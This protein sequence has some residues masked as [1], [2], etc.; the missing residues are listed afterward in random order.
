V[1]TFTALADIV[2]WVTAGSSISVFDQPS[3]KSTLKNAINE[4]SDGI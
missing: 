4:T 1:I 3:L 2:N